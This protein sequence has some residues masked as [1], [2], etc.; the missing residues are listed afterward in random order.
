MELVLGQLRHAVNACDC[1][2][3]GR[4]C[5]AGRILLLRRCLLFVDCLLNGFSYTGID[6]RLVLDKLLNLVIVVVA[7]EHGLHGMPPQLLLI[8][9]ELLIFEVTPLF[10]DVLLVEVVLK[11]WNERRF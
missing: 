2:R 5:H 10:I 7:V 1:S 4:G 6:H 3:T 11:R 9:N 8:L